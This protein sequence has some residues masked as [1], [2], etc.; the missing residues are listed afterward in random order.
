MQTKSGKGRVYFSPW[1]QLLIK[2]IQLCSLYKWSDKLH[3]KLS[4]TQKCSHPD[5]LAIINCETRPSSQ[6]ILFKSM[7][8][9]VLAGFI[10]WW[11]CSYDTTFWR[12]LHLC[13]TVWSRT[14]SHFV[15]LADHCSLG[16]SP[17]FKPD[18]FTVLSPMCSQVYTGFW[19]I[20]I[21][22][23]GL[24]LNTKLIPGLFICLRS[25]HNGDFL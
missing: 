5:V 6:K 24:G 3:A 20:T 1:K 14:Y 21:S 13:L 12:N 10:C 17:Q 23:L 11:N 2:Y 7:C 15:L 4:G 19:F 16:S 22:L 18:M 9:G 25:F 8:R